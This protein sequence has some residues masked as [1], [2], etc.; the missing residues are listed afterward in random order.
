MT[1]PPSA[2]ARLSTLRLS[3][4]SRNGHWTCTP[5]SASWRICLEP[6]IHRTVGPRGR[7]KANQGSSDLAR[8]QIA[9]ALELVP[10]DALQ[11]RYLSSRALAPALQARRR[12]HFSDSPLHGT[13]RADEPE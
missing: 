12:G 1:S 9:E 6:H 2:G 5:R 4:R 3:R 8:R 11:E 7:A 10:P 13:L